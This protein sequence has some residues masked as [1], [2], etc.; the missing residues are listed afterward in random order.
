MKLHEVLD[1]Y[2]VDEPEAF[3]GKRGIPGG[4]KVQQLESRV[5]RTTNLISQTQRTL[6]EIKGLVRGNRNAEKFIQKTEKALQQAE[7]MM[8]G[9]RAELGLGL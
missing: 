8:Q 9:V 6:K 1:L 5:D 4:R 2:E 3:P 7:A